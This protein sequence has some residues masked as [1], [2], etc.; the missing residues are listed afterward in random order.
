MIFGSPGERSGEW[1]DAA[2]ASQIS[3]GQ[4]RLCKKDYTGARCSFDI[5][6]TIDPKAVEPRVGMI[7]TELLVG[8]YRRATQL[9]RNLGHR[10]PEA[11][12]TR[13]DVALWHESQ[14]QYDEFLRRFRRQIVDTT[15]AG[16][17]VRVLMGYVAWTNGEREQALTQ[18]KQA[19]VEVSHEEAW[20]NLIRVLES[21]EEAGASSTKSSS[22]LG[23]LPPL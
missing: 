19:A 10:T 16:E 12:A 22:N 11:F 9:I 4:A 5:A 1:A 7:Q 8:H 17:M 14:E 15:K 23:E 20:V 3:N 2:L 6:R 13:F 21:P 18:M